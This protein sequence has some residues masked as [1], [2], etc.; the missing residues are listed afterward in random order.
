ME[1]PGA[2]DRI[3][4]PCQLI[5]PVFDIVFPE[6]LVPVVIPVLIPGEPVHCGVLV[7]GHRVAA[8][9]LPGNASGEH[10]VKIFTF[11]DD[12]FVVRAYLGL[13]VTPL[14]R[15]HVDLR[16]L[17]F[18]RFFR[19]LPHD[20]KVDIIALRLGYDLKSGLL[21][22][23][24]SVFRADHTAL[25][26]FGERVDSRYEPVRIKGRLQLHFPVRAPEEAH[27]PLPVVL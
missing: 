20:G 18:D 2:A 12:L 25:L 13:S 24:I 21:K 10:V 17:F 14:E 16:L 6:I 27:E 3:D 23:D 19:G 26:E 1:V 9:E 5:H 15:R 11:F 4:V 22:L 7:E 8:R